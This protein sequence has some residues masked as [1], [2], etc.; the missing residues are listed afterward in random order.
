MINSISKT[1]LWIVFI[2]FLMMASPFI[3]YDVWRSRGGQYK[4]KKSRG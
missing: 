2:G 3:Y 1:A 4:G